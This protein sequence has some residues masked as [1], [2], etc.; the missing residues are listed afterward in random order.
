MATVHLNLDN[1]HNADVSTLGQVQLRRWRY[2]QN[3]CGHLVVA[4]M[5]CKTLCPDRYSDWYGIWFNLATCGFLL[6][7]LQ[8]LRYLSAPNTV[9]LK[10]LK[11]CTMFYVVGVAAS[12]G[13]VVFHQVDKKTYLLAFDR[14][15]YFAGPVVFLHCYVGWRA[16][17]LLW[18][19]EMYI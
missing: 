16:R 7:G 1:D 6:P 18:G 8:V 19:R 13:A 3:A 17:F 11:T 4:T 12:I 5:V 9:A 10:A 15:I 2:V 14:L